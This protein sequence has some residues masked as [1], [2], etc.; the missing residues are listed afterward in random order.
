MTWQDRPAF[1]RRAFIAA[2][3]G[4][5]PLDLVLRDVTYLNVVTGEVYQAD[6]G[7]VGDR[8]AHV[9]SPGEDHLTGREVRNRSGL[10]AIPGLIDTHV[11]IESSMV[12]PGRYAEA[13]VPHG[14]TTVLIDPHEIANV[15]GLAGVRFMLD[16]SA[17]LPLRVLVMAP[18]SVPSALGVE[19]AGASFGPKE[20]AEMLAWPRVVGLAEVM[21]YPGVL[22]GSDR[23][24]GEI[25]ET[26]ARGGLI[27]GHAPRLTGRPLSAYAGAGITSDHENRRADEAIA[28]LRAG[29]TLEVRESS[30]SRNAAAMAGV[31]RGRGY[32]P[33]VTLCSDDVTP[34]DLLRKGHIDHVARRLIAEGLD[35]VNVIRFATLN[36]ANRLHREDIGALVPGRLADIALLS[37][38]ETVTVAEVY[39]SGRLVAERGRPLFAVPETPTG[40][41]DTVH[42]PPLTDASFEVRPPGLPVSGTARVR[43]IEWHPAE[44]A[45]TSFGEATVEVQGGEIVPPDGTL[46]LAVV[47]RHGTHGGIS[48]CLLRGFGLEAG[49]LGSTVSHDSHQLT[50]AGTNVADMLRAAQRLAE[51]GGGIVLVNHGDVQA[52]IPLPIAGLMSEAPVEIVAEQSAALRRAAEQVGL[53]E[54]AVMGIV[55]LTLAVSPQAKLSDL[56]LVD[57]ASQSLVPMV[58]G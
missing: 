27:Q 14:T 47:D 1:D 11:H 54:S 43:V 34:D 7:I 5:A 49:A 57:V 16:A 3:A 23:M 38:L 26:A 32:L 22:R 45:K 18:S 13:V 25:E 53:P 40:F 30:L 50:V 21:D 24:I 33:N 8:I 6:I 31:L 29:M 39:R 9:T 48:T 4:E 58:I 42:V 28:K 10:V 12:V 44:A 51:I 55:S 46:R 36:A 17:D 52:E 19:T 15:A 56:G 35:P 20:I 37:D 2:V 41:G